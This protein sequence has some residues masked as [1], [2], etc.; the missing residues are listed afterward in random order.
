MKLNLYAWIAVALILASLVTGIWLH[1]RASGMDTMRDKIA[2]KDAALGAA[3]S[4]LRASKAAILEINAEAD[5]RI[6]LAADQAKAANAAALVLEG[7]NRGIR[8]RAADEAARWAKAKR[9]PACAD[10]LNADLLKTCGV[11]VR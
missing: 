7:E 8:K 6:K 2:A 11:P 10:L 1:G 5:T 3:A 4:A 9:T